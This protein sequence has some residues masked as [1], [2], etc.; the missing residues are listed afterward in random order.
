MAAA[1]ASAVR[2]AGDEATRSLD[3]IER[4]AAVAGRPVGRWHGG[5]CDARLGGRQDWTP[6][7]KLGGPGGQA[8][9]ANLDRHLVEGAE[10]ALG[11]LQETIGIMRLDPVPEE[12]G[13][14]RHRQLPIMAFLRLHADKPTRIQVFPKLRPQPFCDVVPA[15]L[16]IVFRRIRHHDF[17]APCYYV[18]N[19]T[20]P[21]LIR[22]AGPFLRNVRRSSFVTS[23]PLPLRR[24]IRVQVSARA[25]S[26][27]GQADRSFIPVLN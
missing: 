7:L 19:S 15:L 13:R 16:E 11:D 17:E 3:G 6:L 2:P 21:G 20:S 27:T 22:R 26:S 24:P 14:D 23:S 8:A 10:L 1:W 4:R 9:G 12:A 25:S 18:L 5:G